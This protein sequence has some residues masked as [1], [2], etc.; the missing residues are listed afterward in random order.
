M[1]TVRLLLPAM[2]AACGL[3]GAALCARVP[4]SAGGREAPPAERPGVREAL[5]AVEAAIVRDPFAPASARARLAD[6]LE[7]HG[8]HRRLLALLPASLQPNRPYNHGMGWSLPDREYWERIPPAARQVPRDWSR[9]PVVRFTN[10]DLGGV[11]EV[12]LRI[13]PEYDQWLLNDPLHDLTACISVKRATRRVYFLQITPQQNGQ[14]GFAESR[15][16]CYSCHASGPR[17]IRPLN[18]VG[19]DREVLARFNRRLLAYGAC[20]FGDS[21]PP[22]SRGEPYADARCAGCH[23]GV[24]R[25]RLYRIHTR[26]IRFKTQEERTMPPRAN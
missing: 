23:N 15:D 24:L 25:G 8:A 2:S 10:S 13:G 18:A 6:G 21:V 11:R 9:L 7:A 26:P 19:V 20:D 5:L 3:A 12:R 1:R 22:E 16:H 17:V 14:W 4:T